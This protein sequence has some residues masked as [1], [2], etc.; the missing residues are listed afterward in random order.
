MQENITED[1]LQ[2]D[3]VMW[4]GQKWPEHRKYLF[5]VNNNPKNKVHGSH[6]KSMGMVRSVSDLILIQPVT[7]TTCGI[8]IKSPNSAWQKSKIENQLNWGKGLIKN[9]GYYIMSSNIELL[10]KFASAIINN[11]IYMAVNAQNEAYKHIISQFKN[12]TIKF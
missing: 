3:F 5:E 7:A 6:R 8:E 10:S 9:S 1:R 4:F 2:H 12:K 11:N